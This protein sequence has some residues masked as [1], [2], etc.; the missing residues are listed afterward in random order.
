[1]QDYAALPYSNDSVDLDFNVQ[2]DGTLVTS[3]LK[4]TPERRPASCWT[5]MTSA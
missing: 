3:T 5:A 4:L 1:M 2:A